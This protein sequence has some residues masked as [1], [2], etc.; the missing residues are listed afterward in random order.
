MVIPGVHVPTHVPVVVTGSFSTSAIDV[1]ATIPTFTLTRFVPNSVITLWVDFQIEGS[2]R[3]TATPGHAAGTRGFQGFM[4]AFTASCPVPFS[5]SACSV[6]PVLLQQGPVSPGYPK[7]IT[8]LL[9]VLGKKH[10]VKLSFQGWTV[11]SRV[12]TNLTSQGAPV[13]NFHT[14][15]SFDVTPGG[16]G[17]VTLVAPTRIWITPVTSGPVRQR[18]VSVSRLRMNFLPEPRAAGLLAVAALTLGVSSTRRRP[19]RSEPRPR[20]AS[21]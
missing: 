17:S 3:I 2:A 1:V 14:A 21:T 20:R 11:G 16:F 5:P 9:T 10:N 6:G 18:T 4:R 13:P 8:A 15:G 7:V 12:F 19:L